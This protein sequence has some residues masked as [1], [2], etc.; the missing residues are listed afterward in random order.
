MQ[1]HAARFSNA[2]LVKYPFLKETADYVKRLDFK[3]EDITNP[4]LGGILQRARERVEEAISH[5]VVSKN[6]RNP[7]VEILSFPV[8]IMLVI[9]S[10]N[11]YLKKRYALAE[12]KSAYADLVQESTERLILL[13]HDFGWDLTRNRESNIA[14]E[15]RL[16]FQ[17][18]L[19]NIA[20]L[21]SVPWRL[22]NRVLSNGY[23]YLNRSEAARLMQE[24]VR[25]LFEERLNN[26]LPS[27]LPK[28]IVE[29]AGELASMVAERG[30]KDEA[31]SFPNVVIQEAFP[32]CIKALYESF[33]SGHHLSHIGRFALTSF[34]VTIGMPT[35]SVVELFKGFSDFSER[36]TRY[37]VEHIA[38]ERGSRTHYRPPRCDTLRTHGV[39]NNPDELCA[40]IRHPANYYRVKTRG[41]SLKLGKQE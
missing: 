28:E 20:Q 14:H 24:E 11:R 13:G 29:V 22:V 27:G 34:L 16:A 15:L 40:R 6:P 2:D 1:L 21:R 9:A 18:Y 31:E 12:A 3:I 10:G 36:M 33:A 4:E 38:G 5:A 17:D 19:R 37:Q 39:C 8:A 26:E 25:R 41:K 32:P 23:V 7:E 30:A 35:E